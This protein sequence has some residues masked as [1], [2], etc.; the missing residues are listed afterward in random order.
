MEWLRHQKMM[1]RDK[2]RKVVM[3]HAGVPHIWRIREAKQHAKELESVLRGDQCDSFLNAMY[4][5]EPEGWRDSLEGVAR[6]RVITN[7]FTRMRF[8]D[9]SGVLDFDSKLGPLNAPEGYKPWYD[10]VRPGTTKIIFGHWAA[11]EGN[12]PNPQMVAVDT[13]CVWGG[14][15][16]ALN[17]D[18]WQKISCDCRFDERVSVEKG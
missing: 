17:L 2:A 15:L 12:V 10:Y 13:G 16:T 14:K 18:T 5:N 9:A 6:W 4:G 8:I 1:V 11:L 7:Y 3:T